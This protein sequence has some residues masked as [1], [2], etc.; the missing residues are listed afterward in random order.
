MRQSAAARLFSRMSA[1]PDS[2]A[3][4]FAGRSLTFGD[5]DRLSRRYASGLAS[6][7]VERGDRVAAFAESL[8]EAI[9]AMLG[10]YRLGAIHVPINTRYRG[11]EAGQLYRSNPRQVKLKGIGGNVAPI[12]KTGD[13]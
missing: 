7:G 5:L 4:L 9:V 10:H 1:A 12:K 11:D 13:N 8:P 2:E 3:I 6:L